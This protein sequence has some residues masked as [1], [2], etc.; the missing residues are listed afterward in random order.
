M[1]I[2]YLPLQEVSE[3][4]QHFR[5]LETPATLRDIVA[6]SGCLAAYPGELDQL[7]LGCEGGRRVCHLPV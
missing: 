2:I 5:A 1:E 4:P 3:A 7:E 6:C